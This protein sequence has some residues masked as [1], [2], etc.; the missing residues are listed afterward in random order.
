MPEFLYKF[1]FK[2]ASM[3]PLGAV[4]LK[5]RRFLGVLFNGAST[6]SDL[7]MIHR[8]SEN[9]Q[10]A[11]DTM[12]Q[13]SEC[14]YGQ[15]PCIDIIVRM[16][17][18]EK[19]LTDVIDALQ[20]QTYP[21][22]KVTLTVI[23]YKREGMMENTSSPGHFASVRYIESSD[24]IRSQTQ[25]EVLT[26]LKAP[27]LMFLT[28]PLE[29]T[30]N[31][32]VTVMR[33]CIASPPTTGLWEI[34]PTLSVRS[35]YYDSVSLEIPCSELECAVIDRKKFD[36]IGGFDEQFPISGQ[37]LELSYRISAQGY[38]MSNVGLS[39]I[40]RQPKDDSLSYESTN[41][42]DRQITLALMR[43]K[44]GNWFQKM[45]GVLRLRRPDSWVF[46]E[47]KTYPGPSRF[48]GSGFEISMGSSLKHCSNFHEAKP[49]VS[50]IIRTF[51]GRRYWLRESVKSVLN[52]TYP[53]IELIVIED[54]STEH[55]VFIGTI[56]ASLRHGQTVKYLTQAKLGKSA[57]GNLGL[58]NAEGDYLNFLDDDD[59]LF[60][61]HV[62]LLL[63]Q[64]LLDKN[65]VGACALAWEVQ[66]L[67]ERGQTYVEEHFEVNKITRQPFSRALL[68]KHNI[69][70]IQSV[71]FKRELY[72]KFGGFETDRMFLEDWDL[73]F[74]Y[75]QGTYFAYLPQITSIYRSPADPYE[76][77]ARVSNP[78][79]RS[80]EP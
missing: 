33:H 79:R 17:A 5:I 76:R 58:A 49:K 42:P 73:W 51:S 22:D 57:A 26:G 65:A 2:L 30:E 66:T 1:Y 34:S 11:I 70:S 60:A 46:R 68:E 37:G 32:L 14:A 74:R 36:A 62:E 9:R 23:V 78:A 25:A 71:L 6:R 29:L 72:E 35:L 41:Q 18:N 64:S 50:I 61:N 4:D 48:R 21:N 52:Q 15:L 31:C 20:R 44:Y 28:R 7:A 10:L 40:V 19:Q 3:R 77:V 13:S 8:L 80:I 75:T 27:Y 63:R 54:G 39:G 56:S 45:L 12:M 59:L 69:W 55:K 47:H 16:N 24:T 53:N 43:M 67:A 38:R